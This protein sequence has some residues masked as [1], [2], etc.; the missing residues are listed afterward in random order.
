MFL[1]DDITLYISTSS[2]LLQRISHEIYTLA[3]HLDPSRLFC[4]VRFIYQLFFDPLRSIPGPYVARWTRLWYVIRVWKGQF[5]HDNIALHEKYG[6]IVR[7]APGWYSIDVADATAYGIGI[8]FTKSNSYRG[9]AHLDPNRRT[10]IA[11]QD[12]KR[13]A[14]ARK[15]AQHLYSMSSL[16]SYER[17]ADECNEI[18]VD[19]LTRF[20]RSGE[21]INLGHWL[22][23][24]SFDVIGNITFSRRFGFLD[25]GLDLD[26]A[27]TALDQTI[28]FTAI[29]GIFWQ[30]HPIVYRIAEHF[31]QS[32]AAGRNYLINFVQDIIQTWD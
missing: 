29:S 13:H 6:R 23:C 9:S 18:L 28:F 20:A 10:I 1:T 30:F 2:C 27:M 14:Q 16:L 25:Q 17:Y 11:E 3:V 4:F 21:V 7:V 12:P 5:H 8:A 26:N 22:Q 15:S 31:R 19:K 24:Y 32:G